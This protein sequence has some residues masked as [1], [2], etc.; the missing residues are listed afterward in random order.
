MLPLSIHGPFVG[1]KDDL[2][3][4]FALWAQGPSCVVLLGP[5][6]VGKT[7]LACEGA[8][9]LMKQSQGPTQLAWLDLSQ[10]R[11]PAAL[12][13]TLVDALDAGADAL[14]TSPLESFTDVVQAGTELL[15]HH[16]LAQLLVF[17]N[18]E[19]LSPE[20]RTLLARWRD[21]NPEQTWWMTSQ[22]PL[23]LTG[24]HHHLIR[25]LTCAAPDASLD[26]VRQSEAVTL[27]EA[28]VRWRRGDGFI[29]NTREL[30][31]MARVVQALDGIPLALTMAAGRMTLLDAG[32]V[33]ERLQQD[34]G[35]LRRPLGERSAH[36]TTLRR[37]IDH[38]VHR[39]TPQERTIWLQC[40]VF[41]GSFTVEA[42]E[43]IVAPLPGSP[44]ILD[45]LE[46][47]EQRFL[48]HR[49]EPD[50]ISL[51]QSLRTFALQELEREEARGDID[52]RM[53]AWFAQAAADHS[54]YAGLD[55]RAAAWLRRERLNL[56]RAIHHARARLNNATTSEVV[57]I[58]LK[59]V[60]QLTLGLHMGR[61]RKYTLTSSE[62]R[63]EPA[64]RLARAHSQNI[65]P[66]WLAYLLTCVAS[67]R[68]RQGDNV[69]PLGLNTEALELSHQTEDAFLK[70]VLW[71]SRSTYFIASGNLEQA[72]TTAERA[73]NF[74]DA[75][76]T[77]TVAR[78]RIGMN[79]AL[80][81]ARHG[82]PHTAINRLTEA[83]EQ[84]EKHGLSTSVGVAY[85]NRSRAYVLL[86]QPAAAAAEL[87]HA[88]AAFE[89]IGNLWGIA[90]VALQRLYHRAQFAP[91]ASA[92]PLQ[93]LM[94]QAHACVAEGGGPVEE[95]MLHD[96]M[97]RLCLEQGSSAQALALLEHTTILGDDTAPKR[98]ATV[99]LVTRAMAY[100]V[101]DELQTA[102]LLLDMLVTS[103]VELPNRAIGHTT[104]AILHTLEGN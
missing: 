102:K 77:A 64:L 63:L 34:L 60:V 94:E 101:G 96:H 57:T 86:G 17:D 83:I 21:A 61:I 53:A 72:R 3:A 78:A 31:E 8:L 16:C 44:P 48:L 23:G 82:L 71:S 18:C 74:L 84:F 81:D 54:L 40:A 49:T 39:L 30:R 99:F 24:A 98:W 56:D 2:A 7:R 43:G 69:T 4:L 11:T 104:L 20:A 25:P 50:R 45:V 58:H 55:R 42:A 100:V 85:L 62:D 80:L 33:L 89:R 32:T 19:L 70:A 26:E 67:K 41:E 38:S 29:S 9:R 51:L 35:F 6:G 22:E 27:M 90:R 52:D 46:D 5:P 28:L 93:G 10:V 12:L 37:A 95:Q 79:L 36:H 14:G 97:A 92:E 1:R 59:R 88:Q 13:A 68:T 15:R 47:L 103:G 75:N 65:E 73:L 66:R 76:T 91:L 87:D